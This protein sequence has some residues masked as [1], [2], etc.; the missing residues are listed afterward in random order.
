MFNSLRTLLCSSCSEVGLRCFSLIVEVSI[1]FFH[2]TTAHDSFA[3]LCARYST[4]LVLVILLLPVRGLCV[5]CPPSLP[6]S[7]PCSLPHSPS[8]FVHGTLLLL[9]AATQMDE[10]FLS[11]EKPSVVLASSLCKVLPFALTPLTPPS[12]GLILH[13][14]CVRSETPTYLCETHGRRC[15]SQR[16]RLKSE[17]CACLPHTNREQVLTSNR[18][19]AIAACLGSPHFSFNE[20]AGEFQLAVLRE[21]LQEKNP[22]LLCYCCVVRMWDLG[23]KLSDTALDS[24]NLKTCGLTRSTSHTVLSPLRCHHAT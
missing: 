6:P 2:K 23:P 18:S 14:S 9:R 7:L 12:K 5:L 10:T 17:S 19:K 11:C 24:Q 4:F 16:V 20:E 15:E 3:A 22:G 8:P 21:A 1:I 13:G